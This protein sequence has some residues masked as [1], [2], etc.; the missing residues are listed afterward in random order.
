MTDF[1][2]RF[3]ATIDQW[4]DGDTP[5]VHRGAQPG[6]TIHGEHVRVQ[7]INAPELSTAEGKA[8]QAYATQLCPPGTAVT[9]VADKVDKYGRFLAYVILPDGSDFGQKMIAAGQAVP[10]MV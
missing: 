6:V 10:Y 1:S 9:L 3:P 4:H 2:Y 8:A 5:I 7:G